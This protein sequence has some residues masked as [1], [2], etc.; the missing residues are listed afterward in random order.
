MKEGT[1]TNK[2][3]PR[4]TPSSQEMGVVGSSRGA[5]R[6]HSYSSTPYSETQQ[7]K[8]IKNRNTQVQ[9]GSYKE[10]VA[11][12]KMAIIHRRHPDVKLN[13]PQ[14]DLTQVN[15]LSAV[16]AN[17]SG[18]VPPQFCALNLHREYSGLLVQMSLLMSG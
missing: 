7:Q 13:Q 6:P 18:E 11:G 9:T 16:D 2:K 10:A 1:W 3:P 5:K 12:T 8:K 17:P 14:A 15:F 4:K